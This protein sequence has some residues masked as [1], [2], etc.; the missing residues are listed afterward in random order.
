L[1]DGRNKMSMSRLQTCTWTFVLLPALGVAMANNVYL[2]VF[3]PL[4][5]VLPP[6]LWEAMG[7][8]VASLAGASLLLNNKAQKDQSQNVLPDQTNTSSQKVVGSV[9][10]NKNQ[11]SAS[12]MDMFKGDEA[13]NASTMDISKMQMFFLTIV[14]VGTYAIEVGKM[15]IYGVSA[16]H[17]IQHFPYLD[18]SAIALLAVSHAGYLGYKAAPHS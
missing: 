5:V 18:S 12:W 6:E 4:S 3:K 2:S 13:G 11:T 14:L 16:G 1:I 17:G 8:S 15:F 7:I 9:V 10:V